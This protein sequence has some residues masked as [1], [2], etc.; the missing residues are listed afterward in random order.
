MKDFFMMKFNN[1]YLLDGSEW[2]DNVYKI[3]LIFKKICNYVL[4][5]LT[6]DIC[7]FVTDI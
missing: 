3:K 6:N 4:T 5:L 7:S 2:S 1:N